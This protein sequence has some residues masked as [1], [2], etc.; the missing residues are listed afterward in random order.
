VEDISPYNNNR[1]DSHFKRTRL[2]ELFASAV[3]NP[4]VVV[5]AGA[6]FGKSS[7]VYDFTQEYQ[8]VTFWLQLSE[9][10]NVE[11]RFWESFT[12]VLK[13]INEPFTKELLKLGFPDTKEKQHHYYTLLNN[14]VEKKRRIIVMDDFHCITD[15]SVI[16]FIEDCI[17]FRLPPGSSVFLVSR[18]VP[19]VKITNDS[20]KNKIFNINEDDL[21]FTENELTQYFHSRNISPSYEVLREIM[22]EPTAGRSQLT[23]SPSLSKKLPATAAMCVMR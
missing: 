15:T 10:D 11:A 4:L 8:A 5:C 12:H 18:T 1:A 7:A 13:K 17:L 22:Q 14:F 3:K 16:R 2:N 23:L 21:R 20:Y 19:D 9:R 6:G